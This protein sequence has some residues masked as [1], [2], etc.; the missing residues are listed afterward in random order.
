MTPHIKAKKEEIAKIVIAAGDPL[1]AKKMADENLKDVKLVSDIRNMYFYTG[2]YNGKKVSVVGHGMG[3]SSAGIYAH[4]LFEFYEIDR[5]IRVGSGGSYQNDVKV[6]DIVVGV[7]AIG[8]SSYGKAYGFKN[9]K[10]SATPSLVQK[11]KDVANGDEQIKFG[12]I[13]SSQWFYYPAKKNRWQGYAKKGCLAVEM[14]ASALYSIA[15]YFKKEALTM[16]TV[17]DSLVTGESMSA[18]DR[19]NTFNKMLKLAL[20]TFVE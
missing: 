1:R 12:T 4:E 9:E 19:Q 11:V 8:D 17:S 18:E 5:F 20:D 14:E 15:N 13:H 6:K 10:I 2:T 16:I 7:N 3:V